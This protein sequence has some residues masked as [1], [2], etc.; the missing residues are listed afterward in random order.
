MD[1]SDSFARPPH[2]CTPESNGRIFLRVE[3]IWRQQVMIPGRNACIDT[4]NRNRGFNV[5]SFRLRG[6]ESDRPRKVGE[7]SDYYGNVLPDS[8]A[9]LR[10]SGIQSVLFRGEAGSI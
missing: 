5:R 8:K 2:R 9:H 3:K 4:L 1:V 6:I 10:M 7:L